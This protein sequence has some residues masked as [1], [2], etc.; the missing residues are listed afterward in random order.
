MICSISLCQ[1]EFLA[2]KAAQLSHHL[3][4][5]YQISFLCQGSLGKETALA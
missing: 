5:I 4:G 1:E 2:G 3:H